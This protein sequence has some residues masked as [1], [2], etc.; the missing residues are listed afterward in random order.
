MFSQALMVGLVDRIRV[1]FV[2]GRERRNGY[3][4]ANS[5]QLTIAPEQN[6]PPQTSPSQKRQMK[7]SIY[8]NH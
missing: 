1:N 4:A 5:E 3:L 7:I 8:L 2:L 6:P